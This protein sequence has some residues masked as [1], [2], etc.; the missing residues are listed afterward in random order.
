MIQHLPEGG[1]HSPM[2]VSS[3]DA[4]EGVEE[5]IPENDS[6]VKARYL[7]DTIEIHE[8]LDPTL[9]PEQLLYRLFHEDGVTVFPK[10]A[11]EGNCTCSRAGI[12]SVLRDFS[13]EDRESMIED[14]EIVATCEFC[15]AA[16][17]FSP[18]EFG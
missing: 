16:Y 17:R 11:V 2:A 6:W 12:M 8:L 3:G 5:E 4:P 15:S 13:A 18:A 9:T 1:D 10:T 7:L 14:G